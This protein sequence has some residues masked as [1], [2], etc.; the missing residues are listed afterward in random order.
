MTATVDIEELQTTKSEKLLAFVMVAFLLVGGIWSYQEIDDRVRS[1]IELGEPTAEENAAIGRFNDAQQ[2][3]FSANSRRA[4]ARQEVEFRREEF[5]AALDADRPSAALEGRYGA[6]QDVLA[7]AEEEQQAARRAVDAAQPAAG[8]AQRSVSGRVDERR[9]RQEL[10]TFLLRLALVVVSLLVGYVALAQLR[11]RNSR[12]LL[13]AGAVLAFATIMAFGLA[14]DYLTDYFNPLDAGLLVLS[15]I[16]VLATLAAFWALQRYLARRLPHRRV[17]RGQC[18]FCAFPVQGN[19][20]CEGCGRQVI[21][22]CARCERPRR[23]GTSYCAS[24][25]AA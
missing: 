24:C 7:A 19:E 11:N 17:R 9:D 25:G 15:L 5:R 10:V 12:Y 4:Q 13:I 21:A 16:G 22:P 2:R 6:A 18:P 20:R 23:V 8:A 14:G 1:S 3:L